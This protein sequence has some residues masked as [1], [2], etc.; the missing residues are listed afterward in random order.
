MLVEGSAHPDLGRRGIEPASQTE[1]YQI[2]L[3]L[4]SKPTTIAH[5]PYSFTGLSFLLEHL[6]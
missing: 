2:T 1:E 6:P 5:T 4:F 3:G